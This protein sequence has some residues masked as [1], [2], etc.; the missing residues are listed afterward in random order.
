MLK[1]CTEVA[2]ILRGYI[3]ESRNIWYGVAAP[4]YATPRRSSS[5]GIPALRI[6]CWLRLY[7]ARN[8]IINEMSART[9]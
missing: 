2:D 5:I 6:G 7:S 8:L 4:G 1:I 9:M 3:G